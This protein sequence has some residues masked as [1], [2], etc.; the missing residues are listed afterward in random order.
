LLEEPADLIKIRSAEP[1]KPLAALDRTLRE[2]REACP[3]LPLMVLFRPQV[4]QPRSHAWMLGEYLAERDLPLW[5][6]LSGLHPSRM[7][8]WARNLVECGLA[9]PRL[10]V[11]V[12][13]SL[14]LADLPVLQGTGSW[15]VRC[16]TGH[17][18]EFEADWEQA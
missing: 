8:D 9:C 13:G 17:Q 1:S 15:L 10:A 11:Q 6:D 4:Y 16:E 14:S 7:A 18:E 2:L 3:A 12:S 5:A